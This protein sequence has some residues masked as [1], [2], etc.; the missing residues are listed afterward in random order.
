MLYCLIAFYVKAGNAANF[1]I[2][3]CVT[4]ATYIYLFVSLSLIEE[5]CPDRKAS[6]LS[7]SAVN[8]IVLHFYIQVFVSIAFH[9]VS[10]FVRDMSMFPPIAASICTVIGL[11]FIDFYSDESTRIGIIEENDIPDERYFSTCIL[12]IEHVCETAGFDALT[13]AMNRLKAL[14]KRIDIPNSDV[15]SLQSISMDISSKCIAVEDAIN[16]KDASKVLVISREILSL[17]DKIEKRASVA[18]ICFK[19]DEFYRKNNDIAMAQIDLILDQ[20]EVDDEEDIVK[21]QFNLR[22]DFRFK[23]AL[24]F[25]DEDYTQVLNAYAD[26]VDEKLKKQ[27]SGAENKK[28]R[29]E[30][31]VALL[32]WAGLPAVLLSVVIIFCVWYF[33]IQ[34]KGLSYEVNEDKTTVTI[35]GY[36]PF[37][38]DEV[39]IPE[40]INGKKVTV[41]GINTADQTAEILM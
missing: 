6:I 35:T 16:R 39:V 27:K 26:E 30:K 25:A 17:C 29:L 8:A 7:I 3:F 12:Y 14:V 20:L 22:D 24:L 36:N 37:C 28:A 19:E 11:C 40:E 10:E 1:W 18:I 32:T 31:R 41:I 4:T 2:M 38:G 33:G 9:I 23:K 5:K 15:S 34:P 21:A 13:E